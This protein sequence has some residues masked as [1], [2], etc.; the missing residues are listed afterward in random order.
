MGTLR[1]S[2]FALY[3]F[4]EVEEQAATSFSSL[5]R[6]HLIN[7]RTRWLQLKMGIRFDPSSVQAQQE[8]V[9]EHEYH[10]GAIEALDH[11]LALSEAT[12]EEITKQIHEQIR[13][14]IEQEMENRLAVMMDDFRSAYHEAMQREQSNQQQKDE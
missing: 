11:L 1:E 7:E 14:G 13:G 3:D 12:V 9:L 5:Q 10:R 6:E 8:F 4:S 2:K